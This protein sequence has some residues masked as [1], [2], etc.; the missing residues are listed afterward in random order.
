[1]FLEHVIEN[2]FGFYLWI[3]KI[4]E[5]DLSL[6]RLSKLTKN[7][8]RPAMHR[9]FYN[10]PLFLHKLRLARRMKK[11]GKILLKKVNF[12][13][14]LDAEKQGPKFRQFVKKC[15]LCNF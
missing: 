14:C 7:R 13:A 9:L 11:D 2:N 15:Q 1:M 6:Y 8:N 10:E 5:D 4:I 3:C 12:L